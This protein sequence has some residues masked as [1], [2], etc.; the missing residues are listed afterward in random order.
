MSPGPSIFDRIAQL[1]SGSGR[2]FPRWQPTVEECVRWL[3]EA[4]LTQRLGIP[5][6]PIL[7]AIRRSSWALA[8]R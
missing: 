1:G 4:G 3:C 5:I 7:R 8:T 6:N 2:R